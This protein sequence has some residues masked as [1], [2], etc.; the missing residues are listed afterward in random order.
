MQPIENI[1]ETI[2]QYQDIA[3]NGFF[4]HNR[5]TAKEIVQVLKWVLQ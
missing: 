1:N 4:P 3:D 2:K 5:A